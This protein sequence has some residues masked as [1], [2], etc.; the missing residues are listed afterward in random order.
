MCIM[1]NRLWLNHVTIT[2]YKVLVIVMYVQHSIMTAYSL[3]VGNLLMLKHKEHM[4]L[5]SPYKHPLSQRMSLTKIKKK[6][7][8]ND[9][10]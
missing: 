3:R 7:Y 8:L 1:H 2:R 6:P 10:S 9:Y 5:Y 4:Y